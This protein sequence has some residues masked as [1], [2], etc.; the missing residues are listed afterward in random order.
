MARIEDIRRRLEGWS[1]W[2]SERDSGGIGY[3][4]KVSWLR[5]GSTGPGQSSSNSSAANDDA[6]LIDQAVRALRNANQTLGDTVMLHYGKSYDIKRVAAKMGKAESTVRR[7]LEL[8]D[9]KI[10]AWLIEYSE[11]KNQHRIAA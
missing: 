3:P 9:V 11:R 6:M 2:V 4:R 10:Q 5:I 7:N 1:R 8:A